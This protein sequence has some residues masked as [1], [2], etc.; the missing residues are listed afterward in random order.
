MPF[1]GQLRHATSNYW[2]QLVLVA[3]LYFATGRLG[4]MLSTDNDYSTLIWPPS[5]IA[6]AAVLLWGYRIWPALFIGAFATNLSLGASYP[7]LLEAIIAQPQNIIIAAGNTSQALIAVWL[8]RRLKFFPSSL[9][10]LPDIIKFYLVAGPLACLVAATIGTGSLFAFGIIP[11]AAVLDTWGTWWVG[12]TNGVILVTPFIIAWNLPRGVARFDRRKTIS[13]GLLL[14]F[15]MMAM[16]VRQIQAWNTDELNEQIAN[17]LAA[18][19]GLLERNL[20]EAIHSSRS[21]ASFVELSDNFGKDSFYRFAAEGLEQGEGVLSIGWNY[22]ITPEE[23]AEHEAALRE[24]AANEK[25]QTLGIWRVELAGGQDRPV[26]STG[27]DYYAYVRYV[28]PY[29]RSKSAIGFDVSSGPV[30]NAAIQAAMTT[31]EP[32]VTERIQLVQDTS[33]TYSAL[34]FTPARDETG[35]IFGL[36]TNVI[37]IKDLITQS[38][39]MPSSPHVEFRLF[40]L[41]APVEQGMLYQDSA[42]GTSRWEHMKQGRE[43]AFADRVWR[44]EILPTDAYIFGL[45]NRSSLL[46][47]FVTWISGSAL[48]ILLLMLTGAQYE[49]ERQVEVRTAEL[50]RANQAKTDFLANMSHEIRTPMNG[51][52]GMLSQLEQSDLSAEQ[53][54]LVHVSL[55]S[56]RTLLGVINDILDFS[57]LEKGELTINPVPANPKEIVENAL[58]LMS[59]AADEKGLAVKSEIN[60]DYDGYVEIDEMRLQQV[61]YNIIGNAI[62]FTLTGQVMLRLNVATKG[63]GA[64][65][66]VVEVEDTGIGIPEEAQQHVFERFKQVE[67][68][69]TRR[70]QGTGLGLAISREIMNLMGGDLILESTQNVGTTVTLTFESLKQAAKPKKVEAEEGAAPAAPATSLNFLVAEDNPVNQFV[71]RKLVERYGH[72]IKVA[73]NGQ[74]LLNILDDLEEGR[75]EY[76]ADLI[77]MDIQMPEMDGVTA[78][79]EIRKR[80]DKFAHMPI[81]ALTANALPDQQAEYIAAGMDACLNKPIQFAEFFGTIADILKLD[82]SAIA[83]RRA[84]ERADANQKK[85]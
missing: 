24:E 10:R 70:Y 85:A 27:R 52:L 53:K 14:I 74:E 72:T 84:A 79:K 44:M 76:P 50:T 16:F 29:E 55:N 46:A 39:L 83:E 22:V 13:L 35:R 25:V 60:C 28:S 49:T 58:A 19:S 3:L 33:N 78:T 45:N 30:R 51:V 41:S 4:L 63:E 1:Q 47:T 82:I 80:E 9:T 64:A 26:P 32:A 57:K 34:V 71:V 66:L 56:A 62:K 81:L 38:R 75:E 23:R 7:S 37:F 61:L 18:S 59:P 69:K 8:L 68:S 73:A 40:D 42:P 6:L 48:A 31:G 5:G 43:F 36:A 17:D 65:R 11:E 2:L 15:A 20:K 12:D 54:D 67:D 21:L 77:L